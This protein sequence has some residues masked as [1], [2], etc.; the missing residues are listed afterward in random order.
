MATETPPALIEFPCS[1]TIKIMGENQATFLQA[2]VSL[3][4]AHAPEFTESDIDVR[5]SSGGKYTSLSCQV[6]ATSQM[7]LDEIYRSV[8]AHPLVK[9]AL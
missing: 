8:S 2:M 1:F 5:H 3:I 4:Q 9:F 6:W 7:Q